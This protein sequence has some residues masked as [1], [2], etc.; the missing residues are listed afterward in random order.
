MATFL[1][2]FNISFIFNQILIYY[3]SLS[4]HM[5]LI[6]HRASWLFGDHLPHVLMAVDLLKTSPSCL[7][8]KRS[9]SFLVGGDSC[10][11]GGIDSSL[12]C[13]RA[14]GC[15]LSFTLPFSWGGE[16]TSLS[17]SRRLL[18]LRISAITRTSGHANIFSATDV[19]NFVTHRLYPN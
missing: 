9:M 19:H 17:P 14:L 3:F 7:S 10:R 5:L 18:F 13:N 4:D 1:V 12:L 8:L 2:L 15:N 6:S 16:D 11:E